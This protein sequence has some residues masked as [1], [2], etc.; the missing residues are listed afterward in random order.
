MWKT[1]F[2]GVAFYHN[3]ANQNQC[4][5]ATSHPENRKSTKKVM[6]RTNLAIVT[7]LITMVV[8]IPLGHFLLVSEGGNFAKKVEGGITIE[9]GDQYSEAHRRS[10]VLRNWRS[11]SYGVWY[12]S[13]RLMGYINEFRNFVDS[14]GTVTGYDWKMGIA[15]GGARNKDDKRMLTTMFMPILVWKAD[16]S[17]MIDVF[18]AKEHAES[19]STEIP[20][21]DTRAYASFYPYFKKY[22]KL[23]PKARRDGK[24]T[25]M[26]C[27]IYDEGNMFP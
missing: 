9:Q 16:P 17:K 7:S 19:N 18:I 21:W 24:D 25:C 6:S 1:P 15:L 10:G 20:K 3:I 2:A 14:T 22:E 4:I 8:T 5:M 11:R 12:D 26:Q 23:L 27:L 13:S